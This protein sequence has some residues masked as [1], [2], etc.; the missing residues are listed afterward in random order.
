MQV[1]TM[2]DMNTEWNSFD[3]LPDD[4]ELRDSLI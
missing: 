3:Q 4:D 1:K 2:G